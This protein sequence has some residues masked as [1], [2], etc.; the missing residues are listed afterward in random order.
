MGEIKER[1]EKISFKKPS[2]STDVHTN[3]AIFAS[4]ASVGDS[5]AKKYAVGSLADWKLRWK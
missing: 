4:P 3:H 5:P 2:S 1:K